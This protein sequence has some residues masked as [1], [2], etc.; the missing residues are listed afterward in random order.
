MTFSMD[1]TSLL[2][3]LSEVLNTDSEIEAYAQT[4]LKHASQGLELMVSGSL[5]ADPFLEIMKWPDAH[6]I[7]ELI[8]KMPMPWAPPTTSN[9]PDYVAHSLPK[10]HVELLGPEGLVVSEK[11]RLG[12]YGM[13]PNSDYGIRT[14]PAEEVFIM[15][16]GEAEWKK[17]DEPYVALR[18]GERAYHSSMTPHAN[19]TRNHAFLSVYVWRGDVSTDGYV[20]SCVDN[21]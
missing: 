1:L 12:L 18:S 4:E 21:S 20:Y 9:D 16:A 8:S 15:L 10:V 7:C 13:L 3:N 19:R 14:H 6:P 2:W 5:L 11:V 17:N